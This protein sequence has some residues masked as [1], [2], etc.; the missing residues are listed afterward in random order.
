MY[1]R[2]TQS[3]P[4]QSLGAQQEVGNQAQA[5]GSRAC[6]LVAKRFCQPVPP[7]H[8][9]SLKAT[10]PLAHLKRVVAPIKANITGGQGLTLLVPLHRVLRVR[11][12]GARDGSC[13]A[14]MMHAYV[15]GE[16]EIAAVGRREVASDPVASPAI[17]WQSCGFPYLARCRAKCRYLTKQGALAHM[18]NSEQRRLHAA[19]CQ[20][21]HLQHVIHKPKI[22]AI[23]DT[24][25]CLLEA[26]TWVTVLALHCRACGQLQVRG[27]S[28]TR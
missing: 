9:P 20:A 23:V 24:N 8:R 18:L 13:Y 7:N 3:T 2:A 21:T 11:N 16:G 14:M 26:A 22:G 6:E 5:A 1:H 28:A 25:I 15:C 17:R 27:R 10:G 19:R 4:E 12:A